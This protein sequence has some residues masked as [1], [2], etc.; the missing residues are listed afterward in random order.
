MFGQNAEYK[1]VEFDT[2][3]RNPEYNNIEKPT[4]EDDTK[5]RVVNFSIKRK[6]TEFVNDVNDL[7]NLHLD[8]SM[9]GL[10]EADMLAMVRISY[11]T[12]RYISTDSLQIL[13]RLLHNI[14]VDNIVRDKKYYCHR[15]LE[16]AEKLLAVRLD[17]DTRDINLI[18]EEFQ[19]REGIEI[20][21]YNPMFGGDLDLAT[22][23][24][25]DITE[26][27]Y[28]QYAKKFS[29]MLKSFIIDSNAK[30]MLKM[31]YAYYSYLPWERT[32][33]FPQIEEC[34]NEI[35]KDLRDASVKDNREETFSLSQGE[36]ESKIK[37][38]YEENCQPETKLITGIREMNRLLNGGFEQGRLYTIVGV[39]GEGK[40]STMLNLAI[41]IKKFNRGYK[42]KNPGMRPCVV[43]LTMENSVKETVERIY[44]IAYGPGNL[45]DTSYEDLLH[46]FRGPGGLSV[47]DY[48]NIDIV[49]R[50]SPP[51]VETTDYCYR[52]YDE[53]IAEGKE[54]ICFFQDYIE[55]IRPAKFR[56]KKDDA[57]RLE[58]GI[59]CDEFKEFARVK[60]IP[61]I[62]ASQI[63]RQGM[64]NLDKK[65]NEKKANNVEVF[66]RDNVGESVKIGNNSDCMI[67]IAP[68]LDYSTG[69]KWLGFKFA[70]TRY[71]N[72][73]KTI[74]YVQYERHNYIKLVTDV[75]CPEPRTRNN[76]ITNAAVDEYLEK[77][78]G[79]KEDNS[80][81]NA[82]VNTPGKYDYEKSMRENEIPNEPRPIQQVQQPPRM[83]EPPMG[84][85]EDLYPDPPRRLFSFVDRM[86]ETI[87]R[88]MF[89]IRSL[90][91]PPMPRRRM[92]TVL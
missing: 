27:D 70:K 69:D 9:L 28:F 66:T 84:E 61:F 18:L 30:Q 72:T 67:F 71:Q 92:F 52:V 48:D 34:A 90:C 12:R 40:S 10:T 36:F 57:Y 26:K 79:R 73:G 3:V 35:A 63:N 74:F 25:T 21:K 58:L 17:L 39:Q 65:R 37:E 68:E 6:I 41:Q 77:Y 11:C 19:R 24:G 87:R 31:L 78:N 89:S 5:D 43:M 56:G 82:Q 80:S 4:Y 29:D 15:W 13:Y 23:E 86:K 1:P 45:T 16:L 75:D 47:N 81:I 85:V 2:T 91:E 54:P 33:L 88:K 59:V 20:E 76:M 8:R 55:R 22:G 53:L 64:A 46:R 62:T 51:N 49:V 42:T 7:D 83:T 44:N 60:K 32:V 50:Y 14:G 38:Y